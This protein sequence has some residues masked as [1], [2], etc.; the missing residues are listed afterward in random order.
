VYAILAVTTFLEN[1]FPPTPSDVAVALGAFLSH[2]GVTAPLTVFLVSWGSS[3]LGAVVVYSLARRYGRSL[4]SGRL[5]RKLLS[6]HAVATI[7]RE[8]LRFGILGIFIGRLI[9]GV[10]SFVAPF[11]G[12]VNLSPLKSLVPMILASGIWYGALTVAGSTLG[13]EWEAISGFISG[14]N[15][16]LAYTGIALALLIAG[17]LVMR[18]FRQREERLMASITRAFGARASGKHPQDEE[19]A[20]AA[21]ATLMMELAR[22]DETLSPAE[23]DTVTEYLKQRWELEPVRQPPPSTSLIERAKLMEYSNQLTRDYQ[24]AERAALVSRLWQAAFSDGA[25]KH[26]EDR[27]MRRAGLVLGLTEEEVERAREQARIGR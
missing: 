10:R 24:K 9:P 16:T 21:A 11:A 25:L 20:M 7:E 13:A 5:G 23:L 22:A 27:L 8:Y 3:S 4:F 19:A 17:L 6:P 1:C 2:R 12:I 15:Q 14:L 26:H 18:R